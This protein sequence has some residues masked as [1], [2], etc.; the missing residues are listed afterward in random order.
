MLVD[1]E[2][3]GGQDDSEV[4]GGEVV[5]GGK[6]GVELPAGEGE[7]GQGEVEGV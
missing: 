4:G 7:G 6:F 5:E 1:E 2:V 3:I